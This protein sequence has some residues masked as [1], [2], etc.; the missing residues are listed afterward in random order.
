MVR[1]APHNAA[2]ERHRDKHRKETF[3][4]EQSTF[5]GSNLKKTHFLVTLSYTEIGLLIK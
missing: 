4:G 3:L 1:Q 5:L 2:S